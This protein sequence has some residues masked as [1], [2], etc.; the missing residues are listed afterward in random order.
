MRDV[1]VALL[2]GK[3]VES[4]HALANVIDCVNSHRL[5]DAVK[6]LPVILAVYRD[7]TVGSNDVKFIA[8]VIAL[9]Y[10]M[11]L[12]WTGPTLSIAEID[13]CISLA[14]TPF[15]L[16]VGEV[17]NKCNRHGLLLLSQKI[18]QSLDKSL[19]PTIPVWIARADFALQRILGD[20]NDRG[21]G[22]VY[23]LMQSSIIS[24]ADLLYSC[25][26]IDSE[27][28]ALVQQSIAS[29]TP[30]A[31]RQQVAVAPT[32]IVLPVDDDCRS[33]LITELAGRLCYY[34]ILKA[35]PSLITAAAN[36]AKFSFSVTGVE[37]MKREYQTQAFAQ[38]AC[39][40]TNFQETAQVV[41]AAPKMVTLKEVEPETDILEETRYINNPIDESTL[42]AAQQA[43][44]LAEAARHFYGASAKDELSLESVNAI[45][46][47]ALL[48]P[49]KQASADWLV[50]SAGLYFRCKAEFQR[51]KTRGRSCFQLEALVKQFEDAE[52]LHR[53]GFVHSVCY[54]CVWEIKK[55]LGTR[56]CEVGMLLTAYE[57]FKDLDMWQ[58]A[59]DCLAASGRKNQ[60]IDILRDFDE[61]RKLTPNLLCSFG[62]LT[63]DMQYYHR[64]WD[65]S[66]MSSSRSQRSIGRQLLKQGDAQRAAEAF[67]LSLAVSPLHADVWFTLGAIYL[68]LDGEQY[69]A[70]A[71]NAFVRCLGVD[72]DDAQAWGNL[73][74]VY[75]RSAE[76]IDQAKICAWEAVKRANTSWKL[77]ENYQIMCLQLNDLQGALNAE[78]SLSLTLNRENHPCPR[79]LHRL[80][81][82][83]STL[84]EKEKVNTLLAD[85]VAAN[86]GGWRVLALYASQRSRDAEDVAALELYVR[87]LRLLVGSLESEDAVDGLML[88]LTAL[89]ELLEFAEPS[90]V[91]ALVMTLRSIPKRLSALGKPSPAIAELCAE[92]ERAAEAGTSIRE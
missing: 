87:C 81:K 72:E 48:K 17:Y 51:I 67:E 20:A 84:K 29:Q 58:Q 82:L 5:Q 79:V 37:G 41:G 42:S 35:V 46:T 2:S 9:Q 27:T 19:F 53:T 14:E 26:L 91:S 73:S 34:N 8:G 50:F 32:A 89:K 11:Q 75:S 15:T 33:M 83:I 39:V 56:M 43:V 24:Y 52:P 71:A 92:L 47:R 62:D 22:H 1:E 25:N 63:G 57:M 80:V 86:K 7:Q 60:A 59:V 36:L 6:S 23:S 38:L 31:L 78:R 21:Q 65:V 64:A 30:A 61:Q 74:A 10:F 70:R 85:L 4:S 12:N 66:R 44:L 55:E 69:S 3:S 13:D 49:T 16:T 40:V 76:F 54:P 88:C 18:F 28:I 77:W 45:V 90:S 68:R